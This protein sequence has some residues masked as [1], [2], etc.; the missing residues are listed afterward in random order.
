MSARSHPSADAGAHIP[1]SPPAA[2]APDAYEARTQAERGPAAWI[3]TTLGTSAAE[4]VD[5]T[6][7]GNGRLLP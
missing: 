6:A 2:E 1:R 3:D 7:T 4:T 5:W